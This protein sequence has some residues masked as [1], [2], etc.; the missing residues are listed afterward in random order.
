LKAAHTAEHKEKECKA[1]RTEPGDHHNVR[2]HINNRATYPITFDDLP[3]LDFRVS[4][5]FLKGRVALSR[6][7]GLLP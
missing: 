7:T 1:Q 6:L 4:L 2:I 3:V 5:A